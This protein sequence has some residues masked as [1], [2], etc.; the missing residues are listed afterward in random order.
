MIVAN[1]IYETGYKRMMEN[2]R[3]ANFLKRRLGKA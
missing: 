2:E 1:P 3:V